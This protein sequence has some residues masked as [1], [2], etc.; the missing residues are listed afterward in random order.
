MKTEAGVGGHINKKSKNKMK[1]GR[2]DP[3]GDRGRQMQ[4]RAHAHTHPHTHRRVCEGGR[5]GWTK[6]AVM[7]PREGLAVTHGPHRDGCH[8]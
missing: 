5:G 4:T 6:P 3:Q 7:P 8:L 1:R 2:W